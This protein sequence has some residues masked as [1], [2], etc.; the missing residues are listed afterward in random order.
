MVPPRGSS[1]QDNGRVHDPGLFG[2]RPS[3]GEVAGA[4]AEGAGAQTRANSYA[5]PGCNQQRRIG[6]RS[7]ERSEERG[8]VRDGRVASNPS[9]RSRSCPARVAEVMKRHDVL[10]SPTVPEPAPPLG[11]LAT[12]LPF[13]IEFARVRSSVAFTPIHNAAGAPA[14]SLP[15]GRSAAGLPIGVQFAA[16]HG[17]DR[18]LLELAL[19]I[20]AA[21]PWEAMAPRQTWL[22]GSERRP[23]SGTFWRASSPDRKNPTSVTER[24]KFS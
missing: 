22:P 16:A 20:E 24:S 19:S 9:G 5:L 7:L 8:H 2:E 12:D 11:H 10:I 3:V 6:S 18:R 15:L 23:S 21:R 13:D 17:H 4:D 1:S 14:I